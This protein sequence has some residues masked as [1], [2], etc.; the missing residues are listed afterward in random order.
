MDADFFYEDDKTANMETAMHQELKKAWAYET[1]RAGMPGRKVLNTNSEWNTL[2]TFC[3]QNNVPPTLLMRSLFVRVQGLKDLNPKYDNKLYAPFLKS[4]DFVQTAWN[5][6][7]KSYENSELKPDD[8]MYPD[9]LTLV[10]EVQSLLQILK[11]NGLDMSNPEH[12]DA[13]AEIL[14]SD[15]LFYSYAA[16]LCILPNHPILLD[17]CARDFLSWVK[18]SCYRHYAMEEVSGIEVD[19]LISACEKCLESDETTTDTHL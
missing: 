1:A 14:T 11:H 16:R 10:E 15:I 12:A 6:Y 7:K 3:G 5:I 18:L 9:S 17:Y 4:L 2:L 8:V 13:I 19:K